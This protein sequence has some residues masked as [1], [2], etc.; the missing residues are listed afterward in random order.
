MG[1]HF[2]NGSLRNGT[3]VYGS[4]AGFC[5]YGNEYSGYK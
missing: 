1:V 2:K 5:E 3:G 4:V